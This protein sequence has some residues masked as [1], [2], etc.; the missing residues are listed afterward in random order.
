MAEKILVVDDEPNVLA[1]HRRQLR[2]LFD[3]SSAE[4]GPEALEILKRDGPFSVVLTDMRMPGMTGIELLEEIK[5]VAPDTICMMLTGNADQR[6]AVDAVNSGNLFRFFNKP[7]S[8]EGLVQGL[9]D[10]IRQY[11]L[12]TAERELLEGTLSGSI[13]MLTDVLSLLD[14]L[15]F[16]RGT[17]VAAWARRCA[18]QMG[19]KSAWQLSLA[20]SIS[21]IGFAAL[22]S[23]LRSK[24]AT[25]K[26]LSDSEALIARN[27]PELARRLIGRIP[28]LKEV[29]EIVYYSGKG[30]DGSGYPDD[31]KFG[32]D[33]PVESRLLMILNDIARFTRGQAP[34][35]GF[36]DDPRFLKT[37]YDPAILA[38]VRYTIAREDG[39][40][41]FDPLEEFKTPTGDPGIPLHLDELVPGVILKTDLRYT[42]GT[43]ALA[44]GMELNEAQIELL[45]L[46][47]GV[48]DVREPM[49]VVKDVYEAR[50][51][52]AKE[53][54]G[55]DLTLSQSVKDRMILEALIN[56]SQQNW[57]PKSNPNA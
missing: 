40:S 52:A 7:A 28:R 13:K 56:K 5:K 6:T 50:L 55:P 35:P 3:V 11:Q 24:L 48:R 49:M 26:S 9:K 54:V 20:A 38:I 21:M 22:P 41:Y 31:K 43:L 4:S 25:R 36:F 42:N 2:D 51:R 46:N 23:E 14:P 44:A 18:G 57:N 15:S 30:F 37:A 34:S 8:H 53:A 29:A 33:L 27:V 19:L 39:V 10:A 45:K 12:I 47:R 32:E 17:R 1:S 16:G